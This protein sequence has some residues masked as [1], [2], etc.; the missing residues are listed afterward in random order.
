MLIGINPY[1]YVIAPEGRTIQVGDLFAVTGKL[2]RTDGKVVQEYKNRFFNTDPQSHAER[3]SLNV[4]ALI[5]A[6]LGMKVGEKKTIEMVSPPPPK[7]T[8]YVKNIK[9]EFEVTLIKIKKY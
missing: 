2:T 1:N 5:A 7:E 8:E 4:Q 9:C 3:N 6:A